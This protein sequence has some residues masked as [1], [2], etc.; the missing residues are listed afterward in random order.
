MYN[1]R[2]GPRITIKYSVDKHLGSGSYGDVYLIKNYFG[3]LFAL[4][5]IKTKRSK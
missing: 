1:S 3:K 2:V 4:K 5:I